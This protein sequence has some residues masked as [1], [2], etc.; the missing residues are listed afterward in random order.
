MRR[1]LGAALA[2]AL[3]ATG[4]GLIGGRPEPRTYTAKF[5]RAIQIFP[6]GNVR[7]QGVDVGHIQ[8]V[9]NV[10]DAVEVV[11]VIDE[12]DVRLPADVKAVIVPQSLLGER[13]IQLIPAYS[14]GPTLEPGSTIPLDRTAVPAEPD[15]L[16][17]SLQDYLGAIDPEAVSAFVENAAGVLEGTG[18]DL[19]SLIR[20]A[21]GVIGTLA[22][23]REDLAAI[24][25]QFERLTDTL[26]TR[27]VAIGRVIRS[28]NEVVGTLAANRVALEGTV[29]GLNAAAAELA[30]LLIDHRQPLHEDIRALTRTGRTLSRNVDTLVE[31]GHWAERLF[32]AAREAVDQEHDWLRLQNQGQNL[33]AMIVQRLQQRLMELC[34]DLGAP[35]C[36]QPRFWAREAPSL[37][38]AGPCPEAK[39][40][41]PQEEI[42]DAIDDIPTMVGALLD[43]GRDLACR[44]AKD[45]RTCLERRE[46]VAKCADAAHPNRCLRRH[47]P[48]LV[49]AKASD[50]GSCLERRRHAGV[51]AVVKGL[52]RQV[53]AAEAEGAP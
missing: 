14:G 5:S 12:P 21:T 46:I 26:S 20:H 40:T 32:K 29:T 51:K 6:G 33:E 45:R 18:E 1:L 39:R 48:E 22:S 37:F 52:L 7:V 43:Q 17:R 11:L 47:A 27:Q 15:E 35:T 2:V 24:I 10:P 23:K 13:Y 31:T 44:N 19:N 28:Y 49:C 36:A 4:C 38:C 16:L 50:V 30:D 3:A 8:D 42:A 9:R 25:V 53:M 34:E 41:T